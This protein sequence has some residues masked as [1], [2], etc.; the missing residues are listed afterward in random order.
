MNKIKKFRKREQKKAIKPLKPF[1]SNKI[2]KY[3]IEKN[4][5]TLFNI[6]NSKKISKLK[7]NQK[8]IFDE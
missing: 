7:K 3:V 8:K 1:I 4:N 2:K 5:D 6:I